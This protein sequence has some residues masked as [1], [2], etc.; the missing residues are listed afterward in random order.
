M[1]I[2]RDWT[3]KSSDVAAHFD[4]HVREQ[5]PW[6]DIA[7]GAVAHV[8][9]H[10]LPEDG[11]LYDLGASTGNITHQLKDTLEARRVRAVSIEAS[12]QMARAFRGHGE[13]RIADVLDYG[14]EEADVI[15]CFLLLM[16]LPIRRRREFVS[17]LVSRLRPGGALIVFDK[18]PNWEGYFGTV[19]ARLTLAGKVA[20]GAKAADVVAK[21]L[22]LAG[23]QRPLEPEL[24]LAIRGVHEFFRFGEFRGWVVEKT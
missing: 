2:P 15:V 20:A 10:Y 3:F 23:A 9:R 17:L 7:T 13:L 21:E 19:M 4:A 8:A 16:F 24:M 11:L 22:S 6:Y 18:V 1:D 5:L 14:Y 12:E